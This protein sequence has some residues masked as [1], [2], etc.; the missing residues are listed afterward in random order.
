MLDGD[1]IKAELDDCLAREPVAT[2]TYVF[3]E[4]IKEMLIK[5]CWDLLEQ[6]PG[7]TRDEARR[8][9]TEYIR[10]KEAL[11]AWVI[12]AGVRFLVMLIINQ[13]F[14]TN[15]VTEGQD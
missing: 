12:M 9:L 3:D 1:K 15:E 2:G 6:N 10:R 7:I 13:W 8:L 4:H 11:P 14:S 5:E